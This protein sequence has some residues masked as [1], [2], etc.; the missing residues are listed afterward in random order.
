MKVL[1]IGASGFIGSRV[2]RKLVEDGHEL[3]CLFRSTSSR[4]RLEGLEYSEV[5]GDICD[6]QALEKGMADC[7]AVVHLASPSAWSQ[8]RSPALRATVIE[9][10]KGVLEVAGDRRV[11]FVSSLVAV[12]GSKA[13]EV[14]TEEAVFSLNTRGLPYAAVKIEAEALCRE[15]VSAGADVVIVNPSE[16][17]GPQDTALITA[18]TLVDFATSTP[19]MVCAGGMA[20]AHV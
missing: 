5:I 3:R 20:V 6:R 14:F 4:V 15:A 11:V 7:D 2:A 16:V 13:P 9:G 17:Y 8:I 10:T 12:N 19:V 1:V 18:G